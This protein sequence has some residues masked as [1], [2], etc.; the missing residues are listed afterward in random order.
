MQGPPRVLAGSCQSM[1]VKRG[2]T[3]AILR[4]TV[5]QRS[6]DGA[7]ARR[8]RDPRGRSR[9]AFAACCLLHMK[10][11]NGSVLAACEYAAAH[12]LPEHRFSKVRCQLCITPLT[13]DRRGLLHTGRQL[14]SGSS[15][16]SRHELRYS[17]STVPPTLATRPGNLEAGGERAVKP[18]CRHEKGSPSSRKRP[19]R[20]PRWR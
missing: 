10:T 11:L 15:A 3:A 19:G 20:A 13:Q 18:G 2:Q 12:R 16:K 6:N 5:A 17:G 14:P 4:R 7:L 8:V 1:V 9:T